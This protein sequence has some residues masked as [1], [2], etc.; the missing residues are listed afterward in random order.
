MADVPGQSGH[1]P[2][3]RVYDGVLDDVRRVGHVLWEVPLHPARCAAGFGQQTSGNEAVGRSNFS[4]ND[5]LRQD[6]VTEIKG[7]GKMLKIRFYLQYIH[8]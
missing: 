7:I 2:F 3:L 8:F 5:V 1:G 6:M 4:E